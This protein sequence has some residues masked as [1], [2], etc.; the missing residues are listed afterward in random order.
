MGAAELGKCAQG[1]GAR[2]R[3]PGFERG[4]ALVKGDS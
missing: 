1:T 4:P 2:G 3:R